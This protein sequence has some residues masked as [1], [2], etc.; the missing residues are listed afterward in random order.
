M[1]MT[2]RRRQK[3]ALRSRLLDTS[4]DLFRRQG[5][6]RTTV[7]QIAG[8]AGVGKST[9]F[10]HFPSKAAILVAWYR[11]LTL[12]A[13]REAEAIGHP[14][15][16]DALRSLAIDLA[17]RA[18]AESDLWDLKD[19]NPVADDSLREEEYDLDRA[20]ADFCLRHIE[21]GKARHELDPD[22]DG[23]LLTSLFNSI[24]TGTGH[25]WVVSGHRFDLVTAIGERVDFL[26]RA[27][28]PPPRAGQGK[29]GK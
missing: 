22:L 24:L 9:F 28:L 6:A 13:L 7:Q 25:S 19:R 18:V 3:A 17:G 20:L 10:N 14:T 8:E 21:A 15:C 29:Q 5:F 23:S 1:A 26:F 2:W 11:D 4:L 27:A 12:A 16:R